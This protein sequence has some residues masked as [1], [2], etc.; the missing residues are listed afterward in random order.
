MICPT[1]TISWTSR[2]HRCKLFLPV[3][4]C[5]HFIAHRVRYP[6]CSPTF[7]HLFSCVADYLA[8]LPR[9]MP[10][11]CNFLRHT[12]YCAFF[13]CRLHP[14]KAAL[15]R[16]RL[17]AQA[18][19]NA[20]P[21]PTTSRQIGNLLGGMTYHKI[22]STSWFQREAKHFGFETL[23]HG[24]WQLRNKNWRGWSYIL[25]W[26][27]TMPSYPPHISKIMAQKRFFCVKKID[28]NV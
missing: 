18:S 27:T 28:F 25:P 26:W 1:C 2:G 7:I 22:T 10:T 17:K 16:S 3:H 15:C 6:H 14:K 5:L 24:I 8:L 19:S 12:G 20:K 9:L 21:P 23:C 11:H 4:A 13:T